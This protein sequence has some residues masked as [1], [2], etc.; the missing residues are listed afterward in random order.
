METLIK[1]DPLFSKAHEQ[2]E[3]F[4]TDD[5]LMD[6]YW[7]GRKWEENYITNLEA[8][9]EEGFK[10]GFEKGRE[11]AL[12][13]LAKVTE[14]RIQAENKACEEAEAKEREKQARIQAENKAREAEAVRRIAEEQIRQLLA[15]SKT[16]DKG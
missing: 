10:E 3:D 2:V 11:E 6:Q 1:D 8:E 9:R 4:R 13:E 15:K 5:T 12:K 16:D 14:A 7:A